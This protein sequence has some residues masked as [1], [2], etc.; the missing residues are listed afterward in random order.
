M[1]IFLLFMRSMEQRG[2]EHI[3]KAAAVSALCC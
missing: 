2:L 3:I 1:E